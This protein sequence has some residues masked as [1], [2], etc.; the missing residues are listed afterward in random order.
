MSETTAPTL[1]EWMIV[2][3]LGHRRLAG[4]VREV[5]IAGHG[6]LR[7]DIPAGDDGDPGRTQYIAPGSVYALHPVDEA[8]ATAAA[9][10]W[11]P[12]PVKRWELARP[13]LAASVDRDYEEPM[14]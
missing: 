9:Q 7:L 4:R 5:Q 6:F 14:F 11:R 1:D 13:A 8:T 12:E 2:E 10:T 3:L